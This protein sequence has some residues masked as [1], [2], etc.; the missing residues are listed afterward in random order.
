MLSLAIESAFV[1]LTRVPYFFHVAFQ[2]LLEQGH[3]CLDT[4]MAEQ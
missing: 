1:W 3:A 4:L 2:A